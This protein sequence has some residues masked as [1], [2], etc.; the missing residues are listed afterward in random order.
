MK[1]TVN[2]KTVDIETNF[3]GKSEVLRPVLIW[4]DREAV[5]ID[6]G[7]PY[8]LPVFKEAIAQAGIPVDKLKKIIL[9]HHDLDH[10]GG[11]T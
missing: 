10:I 9:T 4:D 11:L 6:T 1:M 7:I 5:L 3:R 8:R 2:L